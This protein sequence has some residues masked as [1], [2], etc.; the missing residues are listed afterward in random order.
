MESAE[1]GVSIK[2]HASA[3]VVAVGLVRLVP[4]LKLCVSDIAS[5]FTAVDLARIAF[6]RR[7][8]TLLTLRT[9]MIPS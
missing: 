8:I 3:G 9:L 2:T 4:S 1:S 7:P 6:A 5:P